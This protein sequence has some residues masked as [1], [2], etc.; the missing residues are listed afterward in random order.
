MPHS[1]LANTPESLPGDVFAFC[2]HLAWEVGGPVLIHDSSWGVV[3]YSTLNQPI[4]DARRS[5]ILRRE[6]PDVDAESRIVALAHGN[7]ESGLDV[8]E[9][10]AVPGVQTRRVVAPVRV[11]GVGVGSIWVA[12][13]AGPLNP[14]VESLLRA[15]AKEAAFYFQVQADWR[16]RE[17]E[18]FVRILL[19][20]TT[21]EA[22][23]TQY[24]GVSPSSR[25]VVMQV[26]HG[27][28]EELRGQAVRVAKALADRHELPHLVLAETDSFHIIGYERPGLMDFDERAQRTAQDLAAADDRIIVGVGHVASRPR[29]VSQSRAEADAVVTYLRRNPHRRVANHSSLHAGV[30]LMRIVEILEG[31]SEVSLGYL[32]RLASLAQEDRDEAVATLNAFFEFGGNAAEAARHLHIHPNTF[33]YRLAKVTELI[34]VDLTDRDER[35][36]LELDL[37]RDRYGRPL[38]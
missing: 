3:A 14:D 38:T 25:F 12:E 27:P 6:V 17:H 37:L 5:I 33:R 34:G 9:T 22:F 13:S 23:L 19:E 21:E 32:Q 18:I 7:F 31:Q 20:G 26:W 30:G 16:A 36:L 29:D 15:A 24:L 28:D 2:N 10:P 1:H 35:L 8:F 4:D 11:L